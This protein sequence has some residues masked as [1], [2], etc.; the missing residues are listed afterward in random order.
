MK[1]YNLKQNASLEI[2][3]GELSSTTLNLNDSKSCSW[4]KRHKHSQSEQNIANNLS[5]F[6]SR[7]GTIEMSSDIKFR[8]RS[9]TNF[10]YS[11]SLTPRL[12]DTD[13]SSNDLNLYSWQSWSLDEVCEWISKSLTTACDSGAMS[14]SDIDKNNFIEEFRSKNIDGLQLIRLKQDKKMFAQFRSSFS[15][16][17]SD[18]WL[19]TILGINAL[20][21]VNE[22]QSNDQETAKGTGDKK[23]D[24]VDKDG[25]DGLSHQK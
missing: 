6:S 3:L 15:N 21:N 8:Y 9:S 5:P 17:S 14:L 4:L 13:Y 24:M 23:V 10:L 1:I 20:P 18:I 11:N 19:V 12:P 22:L 2:P 25:E 7:R 16:Q